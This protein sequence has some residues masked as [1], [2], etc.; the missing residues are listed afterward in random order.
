MTPDIDKV[1]QI[2]RDAA[3]AEILP[4]FR[5]LAPGDVR[6]KRPG[7]KVTP[8]DVAA[9]ERLG[10]DLTA[11]LPGSVLVGEE[12]SETAEIAALMAGDA[13]AW[14]VDPVDGTGN[15]AEGDPCFAVIVALW[16]GGETVAGWLYDPIG[17]TAVTAE[18]G[19]G[20]IEGGRRLRA[21]R[22]ADPG[23]MSGTVGKRLRGELETR[24]RMGEAG[25]P[26]ALERYGCIGQEYMDL[27][28][29]KLDFMRCAGKLKPWDH[30][31]GVLIHAEAGGFGARSTDRGPYRP[32][33]PTQDSAIVLAPD[34]A[35]WEA[36]HRYLTARTA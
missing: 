25:V 36:L 3:A 21:A 15:F 7:E 5:A 2:I 31:A 19:A 12:M 11:L 8:A 24:R 17:D 14:I 1:T 4:R 35:A 28:R 27:A 16:K 23:A 22:R 30:A 10:R 18:K 33:A 29:G 32:D 20:A 13:P 9:E 26:K 6:E 34:A